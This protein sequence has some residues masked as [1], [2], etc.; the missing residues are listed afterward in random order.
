MA[1]QE[2]PAVQRF[3]IRLYQ[4]EIELLWLVSERA[5]RTPAELVRELALDGLLN[6][7]AKPENG[8]P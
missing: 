8:K 3:S 1:Q 2:Q 7:V 6:R 4:P 5:E